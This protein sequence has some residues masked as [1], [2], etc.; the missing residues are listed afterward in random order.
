M[1]S[2]ATGRAPDTPLVLAAQ[3]AR[4]ALVLAHVRVTPF[5]ARPTA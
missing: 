4:M 3:R 2:P 5:R 1:A